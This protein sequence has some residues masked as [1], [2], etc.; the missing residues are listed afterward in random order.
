MSITRTAVF[1]GAAACIAFAAAALAQTPAPTTQGEAIVGAVQVTAT[2]VKIDQATRAVTLKTTDGREV[3]F[4]ADAAV[5]NLS[6]VKQGDQVVATYTEALA[7]EVKKGGSAGASAT[8]AGG[9]AKPGA[10]PAAVIGKQVTLT[11]TIAA[12]DPKV[13]SVTFKGPEGN[14][15]TIKVLRPE[16]LQ[17]VSVGDTVELTYTE[18]L[19]IKVDPAPRK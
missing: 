10:R 17:G 9:T 11:V 13:P 7:Y 6:Q 3:S 5:K 8:V 14:T 12:I 2:V 4:V 16:R 18:A 15:R 1:A 19:A